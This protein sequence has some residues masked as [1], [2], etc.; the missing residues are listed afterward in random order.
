MTKRK[1]EPK[2]RGHFLMKQKPAYRVSS[3]AVGTE[4]CWGGLH[5]YIYSTSAPSFQKELSLSLAQ[6]NAYESPFAPNYSVPNSKS[7]QDS[8]EGRFSNGILRHEALE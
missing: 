7:C 2:L 3:S 1:L 8:K 4:T 5:F 6:V